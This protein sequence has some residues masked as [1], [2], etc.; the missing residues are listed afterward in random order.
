[1][2]PLYLVAALAALSTGLQAAAVT[3]TFNGIAG[4]PSGVE[5]RIADSTTGT[6]DWTTLP[7]GMFSYTRTGGDYTGSFQPGNPFFAFCLEPQEIAASTT[8]QVVSLAN[9]GTNLNGIGATRASQVDR[10]L[11]TFYPAFG[12]SISDIQVAAIQIAIWEIVREN[13]GTLNVANGTTQFRNATNNQT[14]GLAQMY[15]N[16]VANGN[17]SVSGNFLALN[18]VGVQ[19]VV[20]RVSDVPE[21]STLTM[22]ALGGLAAVVFA[23]RKR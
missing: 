22:F 5:R 11:T 18:S 16:S 21:P 6:Q 13:S 3:V 10:L 4:I 17:G 8:F 7:V 9:G 20:I 19:D 12:P 15:L 14:L 2:R 1:M 23:R